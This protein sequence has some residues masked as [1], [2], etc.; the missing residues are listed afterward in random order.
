MGACI[1]TFGG[2]FGASPINMLATNPMP[3]ISFRKYSLRFGK[4]QTVMITPSLPKRLLSDFSLAAD[5]ST[6]FG[7]RGDALNPSL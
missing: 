7:D 5:R 3:K 1:D 4:V 2:W 6:G